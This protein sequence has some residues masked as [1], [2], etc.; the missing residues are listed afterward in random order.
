[1]LLSCVFALVSARLLGCSAALPLYA[2]FLRGRLACPA[3]QAAAM[4]FRCF[5]RFATRQVKDG[6]PSRSTAASRSPAPTAPPR[7]SPDRAA[8]RASLPLTAHTGLLTRVRGMLSPASTAA[9][10]RGAR[11]R[12]QA[13]CD[14]HRAA[15]PGQHAGVRGEH[16]RQPDLLQQ[17]RDLLETLHVA[18]GT[19]QGIDSVQDEGRGE[20]R[21]GEGAQNVHGSILTHGSARGQVLAACLAIRNGESPVLDSAARSEA[22]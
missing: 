13:G 19:G 14:A 3:A 18:R 22:A 5:S 12:P 16:R 6:R 7:A 9:Q 4:A 8:L 15:G 10:V 1:M 11:R 20:H 21:A 17:W 2:V